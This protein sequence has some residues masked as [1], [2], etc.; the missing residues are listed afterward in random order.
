MRSIFAAAA[1]AATLGLSGPALAD[2]HG[3]ADHSKM[4]HSK[5]DHSKMDHSA[6]SPSKHALMM[7]LANEARADDSARDKYRNPAETLEFFQV[8][9]DQTVVEYGPGGGWYTRVLA[10]YLADAGQYIAID[11]DSDARSYPN[12]EAEERTRS[13]PQRFPVA[14]AEWSGID[15]AKI[16]AFESDEV[17]EDVA[18]T[19]DRALIF[20][21][22]HGLL[23]G[24][25][26][27]SELRNIRAMLAEDGMVG[28]VQHRAKADQS[29]D[30]TK[31]SRGYLKQADVIKLFEINGFKLVDTSEINANPNDP[32]DWE[33]GVWTLP[34]VLRYGDEDRA[35]YEAVGESDRMTLLFKKAD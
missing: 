1:V 28:V 5:M 29:Y 34:P 16:M 14:A 23:N 7:V 27:D 31:G 26:A 22:I 32:A 20:R 30:M 35:K 6:H 19:I 18:G 3:T 24:N 11:G 2:H 17:S 21:S 13:W 4:D 33:G 10:P 9:P 12:P 8:E 15:A 25:R